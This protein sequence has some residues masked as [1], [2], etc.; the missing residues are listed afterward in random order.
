MRCPEEEID[1]S[2]RQRCGEWRVSTISCDFVTKQLYGG[3][4]ADISFID[5]AVDLYVR[6]NGL[7]DNVWGMLRENNSGNKGEWCR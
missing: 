5:T 6:N 3:G 7:F 4:E 1:D 2:W